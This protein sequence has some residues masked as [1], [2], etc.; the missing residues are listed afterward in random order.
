M[1]RVDDYALQRRESQTPGDWTRVTTTVVV[2]GD[3]S[4]G[5]GEDVTYQAEMHDD[6]AQQSER[7]G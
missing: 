7:P 4:T 6:H 1:G 2:T 5:E 3:G